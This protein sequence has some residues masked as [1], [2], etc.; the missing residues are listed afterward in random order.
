MTL[1]LIIIISSLSS[2]PRAAIP[3]SKAHVLS[4][5]YNPYNPSNHHQ[6]LTI[7][8]VIDGSQ[9]AGR[10]LCADSAIVGVELAKAA[11][12]MAAAVAG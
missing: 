12:Y 4:Y 3:P 9:A 6:A 11:E 7:T 5:C 1:E 10:K 2:R 8:Q